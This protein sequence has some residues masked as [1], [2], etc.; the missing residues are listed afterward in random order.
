LPAV[1]TAALLGAVVLWTMFRPNNVPKRRIPQP[2]EVIWS[3]ARSCR[4]GDVGAYLNC[5]GSP[6]REWLERVAREQGDEKFRAY[7]KQ[8]VAPLKGIAVFEPKRDAQGNWRVVAEFVF[9]DRTERQ[10]F[11]VRKVGNGWKIVG[12]ESSKPVP[13]LIPYGTPV[14]GL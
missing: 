3:L 6:L 11:L 1:A 4:E 14:K 9:A 8:L 12:V 7:L 10:T 13:V 2:D 5:F